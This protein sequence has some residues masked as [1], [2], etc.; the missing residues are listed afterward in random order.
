VAR[1]EI[2][3]K[4]YVVSLR[5]RSAR[6]ATCAASRIT[7]ATSITTG[8][9]RGRDVSP[10]SAVKSGTFKTAPAAI[11]I[12]AGMN[13]KPAQPLQAEGIA[14][15]AVSPAGPRSKGQGR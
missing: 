3:V 14:R 5:P 15:K 4:K 7:T 13:T 1:K 11:A 12:R 2:A 9:N 8:R 6:E 10:N